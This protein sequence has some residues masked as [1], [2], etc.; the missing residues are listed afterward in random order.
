MSENT[1]NQTLNNHTVTEIS[2]NPSAMADKK[3]KKIASGQKIFADMFFILIVIE[4]LV[5]KR[6][7]QFQVLS[8]LEH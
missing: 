3:F 5:H 6:K 1:I 2:I 4:P 8:Y 7:S